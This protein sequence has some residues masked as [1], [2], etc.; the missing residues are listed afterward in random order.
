MHP[1]I[2]HDVMPE[3]AAGLRDLVLVMGE[4]EVDAAAMNVEYFAQML[5]AHGRALDVPAGAATAPRAVPAGRC[6]VRRLPQHEI[7]VTAL[8]GCH[9]D[10]RTGEHF[11]QRAA[12]QLPIVLHRRHIEQHMAIRRIG[13]AIG[14]ELLDDGDH[15]GDVFGGA[16]LDGGRQNTQRRDVGMELLGRALRHLTDRDALF[17]RLCVD[18]VVHIRDVAHIGHMTGAVNLAQQP[19]QHVEHDDGPRIA[20]MGIVVNRGSA[21][22]HAHVL[23]VQGTEVFLGAGQRV[24]EAQR[25]VDPQACR[26]G[27]AS[28][29]ISVKRRPAS[30]CELAANNNAANGGDGG[31][32]GHFGPHHAS[33]A[34]QGQGPRERTSH[35]ISRLFRAEAPG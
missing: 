35:A 34:R 21:D 9:I 18:L 1:D 17:P 15:L 6:L 2:R 4:D 24:V 29:W 14:D 23:E 32:D 16:R 13:V 3:G 19:E 8:V 10:T 25:H 11:I 5:P 20:D 30:G 7:H 22:I 27:F 26:P 31:A 33:A 28:S 12:R